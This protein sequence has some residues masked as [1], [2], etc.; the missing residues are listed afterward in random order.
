MYLK[1]KRIFDLIFSLFGLITLA[2]VFLLISVAIR[3]DTEGPIIFRQKRVG[4]Y[5]TTFNLWKFRTMRSD[6]PHD[7][8]THLLQ[9]EDMWVTRFGG[10]LRRSSLDELP[11]LVNILKGDMSF[12]GPR[13]A[14][15][16]QL[17]LIQ[18]RDQNGANQVPAGLTG[19]A[20]INGR[21]QLSIEEKARLDGEYSKKI[22]FLFDLRCLLKS[23]PVVVMKR[24]SQPHA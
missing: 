2:P 11:Q 13:P 5:K 6:A 12:V 8:A 14:L 10:F 9:E 20:Q 16:N 19:W 21:D 23:L 22:S 1:V 17:D 7:L 18:A 3:L 15:W 24:G 4:M